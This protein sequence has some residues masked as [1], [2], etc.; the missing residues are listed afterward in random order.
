MEDRYSRKFAQE[1]R[2]LLEKLRI[3]DNDIIFI[4][5]L[6]RVELVGVAMYLRKSLPKNILWRFLFRR[7]I[8][9]GREPGYLIQ[10]NNQN[11][12]I[13]SFYFF[14][15]ESNGIDSRF[16]TDT[17]GLSDQYNSLGILKFE[18][19]PIPVDNPFFS[20]KKIFNTKNEKFNILYLGDARDEKGFP[21]LPR[22]VSD[23]RTAGYDKEKLSFTF[24]SNFN[25]QNGEPGSRIAKAELLENP[26]FGGSLIEGPFDSLKYNELINQA[27]IILIPY[28]SENYYVRSS[29]IFA[30]AL[31]AGVPFVSSDK[32]WMSQEMLEINQKYYKN[33]LSNFNVNKSIIINTN[34]NYAKI[35]PQLIKE[36]EYIWILFEVHPFYK[37]AG[38][39]LNI[40][41][42][43]E[44]FI[45]FKADKNNFFYS[46]LTIDLRGDQCFGLLRLPKSEK[47]II[48]FLFDE[49]TGMLKP[50]NSVKSNRLEI[51][52][53]QLSLPEGTTLYKG[54]SF[55]VREQ[56][57]LTA[58][59]EI[60]ENILQYKKDAS[61][62]SKSWNSFH[63]SKILVEMMI[64]GSK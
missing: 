20:N 48:E 56:D 25:T 11:K 62:I 3:E 57:F 32:S 42:Q 5:T 49:G 64:E 19:L 23:I 8:F 34:K 22:L 53:H 45:I 1:L 9:S 10:Y 29:G 60:L 37:M 46:Q 2:S 21:L 30:E 58:T 18:T 50:L 40:I 7:N 15:I 52:A 38:S 39:Y 36:D 6:G 12:N 26:D 61:I 35:E 59:L 16:Y 43:N 24:Q 13:D 17:K 44:P 54:G 51:R 41:W 28:D 14:K 47:I 27:D 55:F 4:P 33:L 31:S 63:N